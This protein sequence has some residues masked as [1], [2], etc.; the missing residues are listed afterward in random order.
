[1]KRTLSLAVVFACV[2]C[3]DNSALFEP[4]SP[5]D[6]VRGVMGMPDSCPPPT[7]GAGAY[8]EYLGDVFEAPPAPEPLPFEVLA[9]DMDLDG[10]PDLLI[11]WHQLV[12]M[13]LFENVD[14]RFVLTNPRGNDRTGLWDSVHVSEFFAHEGEL[15]K[16]I[17]GDVSG[18]YVWHDIDRARGHWHLY[19]VPPAAGGSGTGLRGSRIRIEI[20]ANS[21]L[22]VASGLEAR[23]YVLTK[24]TELLVELELPGTRDVR[25]RTLKP[26]PRLEIRAS[27]TSPGAA[28]AGGTR[29]P[30]PV[31]VGPQRVEVASGHVVLTKPDPHGMAWVQI[32]GSPEPELYLTRGAMQ[33]TSNKYD[34]FFT[35]TG[36]PHLFELGF[37]S[38]GSIGR[39]RQVAWVDLE[40]D[41]GL[42]LYVSNESTPNDLWKLEPNPAGRMRFVQA[43]GALGLDGH[44]AESF[45]WLDLDRDG[46]E[47][48]IAID[49]WKQSQ[50]QVYWNRAGERFERVPGTDL[51]LEFPMPDV[52]V[53][54]NYIDYSMHLVDFDN[55]G[56]LD[57]LVNGAA[58]VLY[59]QDSGSFR[60]LTQTWELDH[61]WHARLVPLDA[62]ADSFVDLLHVGIESFLLLNQ[63]GKRFKRVDQD[64]A[65]G[66][67][68]G[69]CVADFDQNGSQDLVMAGPGQRLFARNLRPARGVMVSIR[70]SGRTP[71]VGALV[72]AHYADGRKHRQRYGSA[73][74]TRYSQSLLPLHFGVPAHTTLSHFV[75]RWPGEVQDQRVDVAPGTRSLLLE[76]P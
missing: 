27:G 75:V 66:R 17:N 2:S 28:T 23:E 47:D 14:G 25:L 1:M 3:V 64:F 31:F 34:R 5:G 40:A 49:K 35:Y 11:N 72:T 70:S 21:P 60:D 30:L 44:G 46:F 48:M 62:N 45:A 50:L 4:C 56:E 37:P 36:T 58:S 18:L 67:F 63:D 7:A 52:R 39:G 76:Q 59:M 8:F 61:M 43:A 10:D 29:S 65:I 15:P 69:V 51:G 19:F 38:P 26:E 41:G 71:P 54:G 42:E 57:L 33:G 73:Y 32:E 22:T 12:R 55:N 74:S 6:A 16:T 13:E 24:P 68:T 9:T 20:T 53:E